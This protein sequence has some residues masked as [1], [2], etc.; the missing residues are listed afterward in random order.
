[1]G[2][3]KGVGYAAK[4]PSKAD[5]LSR[6]ATFR[7]ALRPASPDANDLPLLFQNSS[8]GRFKS[9]APQRPQW[10]RP[11][12]IA[13]IIQEIE[14]GIRFFIRRLYAKRRPEYKIL[15]DVNCL[16]FARF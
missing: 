12:K 13:S 4:A 6:I 7:C 1:L 3:K 11:G 9:I 14:S 10:R 8:M 16:I 15:N 2:N 5:S